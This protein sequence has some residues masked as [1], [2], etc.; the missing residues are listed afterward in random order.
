MFVLATRELSVLII[1]TTAKSSVVRVIHNHEKKYEAWDYSLFDV[2]LF[3]CV[4]GSV[5][6]AASL[7]DYGVRINVVCPAFV[8]TPMLH[9]VGNEDNMG[10]FVKFQD[11]FKQSMSKFGVLQ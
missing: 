11:D 7:G 10:K 1:F 2:F 6:D 4:H 8:N 9:S 3:L 5:Q